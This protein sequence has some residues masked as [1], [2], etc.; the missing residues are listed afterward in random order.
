MKLHQHLFV[1]NLYAATPGQSPGYIYI[2]LIYI[3]IYTHH[4]TI[5]CMYK[6]VRMSICTSNTFCGDKHAPA[7]MMPKPWE[8]H[9]PVLRFVGLHHTPILRSQQK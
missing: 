1:G 3:Y 9:F 6:R 8:D 2:D 7:K 4:R 5:I